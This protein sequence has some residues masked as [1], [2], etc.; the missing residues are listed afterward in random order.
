MGGVGGPTG[1][2]LKGQEV[3]TVNRI[4]FAG[5]DIGSLTSKAVLMKGR[6]IIGFEVIK[7]KI[8]PEESAEAVLSAVLEK[9][10]LKKEDIAGSTGTGY[11]RE[12]ITFADHVMS[13]I[14]CHA[15][16]AKWLHPSVRT[17]IDIGGQDAKVLSLDRAGEVLNFRTNDKCAA[18]TGRFLEVMAKV[19]NVDLEEMGSLSLKSASPVTF[20]ATCTV[21]AQAD[22][23]KY[24]NS[25]YSVEDIAAGISKAMASRVAVLASSVG[26]EKDVCMT[27]G[28]AK[29]KG[30]VS[31]LEKLIGVK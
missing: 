10:G 7:S 19:L 14:A 15:K 30:V 20:A 11:G 31:F 22:A 17:V 18:G 12:R 23:I 28:V 27:G 29:N 21:W 16:G 26:T 25:D 3:D 8:K 24:L 9:A 2:I 13:E 4:I 6:R 1:R 5:C